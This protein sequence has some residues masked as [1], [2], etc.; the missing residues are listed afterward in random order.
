MIKSIAMAV[1]YETY[2]AKLEEAKLEKATW[3]TQYPIFY[4]NSTMFPG[5]KLSLM[6]FEPR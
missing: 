6:L 1:D 5:N 2:V 4:Y 3:T